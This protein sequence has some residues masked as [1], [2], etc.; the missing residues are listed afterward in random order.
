MG[1]NANTQTLAP[2][3]EK[4]QIDKTGTEGPRERENEKAG[5]EKTG[6]SGSGAEIKIVVVGVRR[7]FLFPVPCRGRAAGGRAV[8]ARWGG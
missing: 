8:F 4:R 5:S 1:A 2:T 3:R 7:D 6:T